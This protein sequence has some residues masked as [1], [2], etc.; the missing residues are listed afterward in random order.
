MSQA[1]PE[2]LDFGAGQAVVVTRAAPHHEPDGN[3]DALG[4]F[5]VRPN[6]GILAVADGVGGQPAGANAAKL[7]LE[8]LWD[9]ALAHEADRPLRGA[10]LDAVEAA[11]HTLMEQGTGS[12]TTLVAAE[13]DGRRL[14]PYH[15]GDSALLVVGGRGKIKHQTVPH[16]PVGYAVESGL[17]DEHEAMH[18]RMRHV[19]SNA[20]GTPDMR[21][22]IGP[23]VELAAR[24][25]V[26]LASD[27]VLDNLSL[28]E[29]A[30]RVRRGPLFDVAVAMTA[31]CLR[32][33]A[34][35]G[36]ETPSKPDDLSLV[37]YRPG[38]RR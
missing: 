20:V 11:N 7:V 22:E 5:P 29:I 34:E 21:I 31:D 3:E 37:L 9:S 19:I 14:R 26:V 2:R 38:P 24:D 15:A 30:E 28:G 25:T 17:L 8:L 27:G 12:A 13:I 6:G 4:V 1:E 16:S 33:M 18:H 10:I 35:P 32:R 36:G 23:S